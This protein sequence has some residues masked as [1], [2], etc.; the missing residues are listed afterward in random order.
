[1]IYDIA[2]LVKETG[3]LIHATEEEWCRV[4]EVGRGEWIY[5]FEESKGLPEPDYDYDE[6]VLHVEKID[7]YLQ[8]TVEEYG[9]RYHVDI[10]VFGKL[11]FSDV[12]GPERR[13]V[14]ESVVVE[15]PRAP[16]IKPAPPTPPPVPPPAPAPLRPVTDRLDRIH[17]L[18]GEVKSEVLDA[19]GKMVR[20]ANTYSVVKIDL[21]V[22]RSNR[23]Y[24]ISGHAITVYKNTGTFNIKIGDLAAD[25]ITVE[26][27]TYPSMLVFD[28]VVFR[29]FF[30][31]NSAQPGRE[32]IL[33]V[34]R[35]E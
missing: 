11:V 32:A 30:I 9:G 31:S 8:L 25:F 22:A 23:E 14:G 4:R 35:R 26:P 3:V 24:V 28:R 7:S 16:P 15:L 12:G 34:W 1:M 19:L 27:L 17:G 6:P 33:I 18:L 29:R 13:H 21:S 5:G 20:T 10:Y 2:V